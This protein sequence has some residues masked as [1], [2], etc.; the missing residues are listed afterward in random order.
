[1]KSASGSTL[2]ILASGEC[3]RADLYLFVLQN[4][5]TYRFT[6]ADI[7]LTVSGN[8]YLTGLIIQRGAFTQKR[9]LEVDSV[10]IA[11]SPQFDN[12]DGSIQIGGVP[13][14]Q[15]CRQGQFDGADVTISKLFL[16]SW[17]D[18][19]PGAVA[20]FK[21]KVNQVN[22]GRQVAHITLNSDVDRL[23]MQMPRNVYQSGCLHTLFDSGC[24]LNRATFTV[25]GATSGTPTTLSFNTNLTQA[26]GYF[27]LG[28][29]TFTSG[30]NS[31]LSRTVKSYVN[32][33]G[34]VTL[35]NPLPSAPSAADTFTI[36]P[37]CDKT[38]S[39][40]L[41]KFSNLIHF[42]GYPYIPNPE[43][44]YDG[45]AASTPPAPSSGGQT[46]STVGSPWSSKVG[47]TY[48]P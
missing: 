41:N 48:V 9:G 37:G 32:S 40:C 43:T 44:P 21:G 33:S 14:L 17:T 16:S 15:A 11:I 4:G 7:P 27:D 42:R 25:S 28:I 34:V 20:W 5:G 19:S 47:N 3:L 18:T 45:G 22:A 39:T 36:V 38:Q 2:A 6:T 26:D 12:P 24:T 23:N 1:M 35:V 31:G 29:V 10:D 46:D 30:A 13:F 8:Q